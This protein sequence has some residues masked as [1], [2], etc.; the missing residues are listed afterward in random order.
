MVN[1]WLIYGSYMVNIWLTM[2]YNEPL[3]K[4]MDWKSVGAWWTSQ[5]FLVPVTTNQ[6]GSDHEKNM[7]IEN[8]WVKT[9]FS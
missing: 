5:L 8:P 6:Q 9:Y 2:I 7:S 1:I 4:M 3:W